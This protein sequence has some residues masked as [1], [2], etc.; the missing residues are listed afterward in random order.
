MPTRPL[1]KLLILPG[2]W[3]VIFMRLGAAVYILINPFWGAVTTVSFDWLDAYILIHRLGFNR[4]EYH[5]LDKNLD[6]IQQTAMLISGINHGWGQMLLALFLFRLVGQWFFLK[7]GKVIYF[8]FFPNFFEAAY[9]WLVAAR[10]LPWAARLNYEQLMWGLGAA[11]V[12]KQL[13]EI[14]LHVIWPRQLAKIKKTGY[15]R[16]MQFF[17]V[18]N[19]G[20]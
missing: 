9:L 20:I 2:V 3:L 17:G 16:W 11:L 13:H 7:T 8:I 19:V 10:S 18:H 6:W 5:F 1:S 4:H 15:P 12:L 14:Y